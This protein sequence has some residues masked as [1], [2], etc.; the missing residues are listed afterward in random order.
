[1]AEAGIGPQVVVADKALVPCARPLAWSREL[2]MTL[3]M[4]LRVLVWEL[5]SQIA[6]PR[7]RPFSTSL[8]LLWR[9][10]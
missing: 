6:F 9:T 1:M 3:L 4:A 5:A 2:A 8:I 7:L 10:P